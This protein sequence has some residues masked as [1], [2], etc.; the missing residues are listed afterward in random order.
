MEEKT[1]VK[2]S[3]AG[4]KKWVP[5]ASIIEKAKQFASIGLTEEQIAHNLGVS[6]ETLIQRKNE[7]PELVAAIKEGK[8]HGI[9]MVANKLY[10]SAMNGNLGAQIF[11]L[12]ARASWK[13]ITTNEHTGLDGKPIEL[14]SKSNV[15]VLSINDHINVLLGK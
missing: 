13:E 1:P 6:Q 15:S 2:K 3:N 12:K 8:S 5:D 11:Y 10:E 4:R 7:Y 9:G 14:N